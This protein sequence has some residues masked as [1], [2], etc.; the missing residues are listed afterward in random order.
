[1][2]I[3]DSPTLPLFP[4]GFV[5]RDRIGMEYT[6]MRYAMVESGADDGEHSIWSYEYLAAYTVTA[7]TESVS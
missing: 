6:I 3:R 2:C 1:M 5:Y 7:K 4:I